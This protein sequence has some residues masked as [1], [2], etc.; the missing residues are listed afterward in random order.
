MIYANAR[1]D[2]EAKRRPSI[3]KG[4]SNAKPSPIARKKPGDRL[5]TFALPA[6]P[7][8]IDPILKA[9]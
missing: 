2:V 6:K 1:Q 5:F 8:E 9:H 4:G 3:G 7:I